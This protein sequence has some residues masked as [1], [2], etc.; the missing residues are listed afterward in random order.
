MKTQKIKIKVQRF[1][2]LIITQYIQ[3]KKII[4]TTFTYV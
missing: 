3:N 4:E 2:S 1:G